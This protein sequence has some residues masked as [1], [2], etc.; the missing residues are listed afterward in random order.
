MMMT[1]CALPF[2]LLPASTAWAQEAWVHPFTSAPVTPP[3]DMLGQTPARLEVEDPPNVANPCHAKPKFPK[4]FHVYHMYFNADSGAGIKN[5]NAGSVFGI[6]ELIHGRDDPAHRTKRAWGLQRYFNEKSS[7]ALVYVSYTKMGQYQSCNAEHPGA[8]SPHH[9]SDC[10]HPPASSCCCSAAPAPLN[11]SS[12]LTYPLVGD[13]KESYTGGHWYSFNVAGDG[14]TWQQNVCPKRE[15]SMLNV[16][17][18]IAH[19]GG[20]DCSIHATDNFVG[21]AKCLEKMSEDKVD[22][23][24]HE[25]FDI[26]S[27]EE[28]NMVV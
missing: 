1:R 8:V 23:A 14:H 26:K 6:M 15:H 10:F 13:L 22:K 19:H 17:H 3:V 4:E 28:S 24:F 27:E 18:T 25:V 21:C 11:S 2:M 16:I 20:C 5:R 12:P 9:C 7:M